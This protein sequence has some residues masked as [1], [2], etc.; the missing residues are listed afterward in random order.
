MSDDTINGLIIGAT[1]V[2]VWTMLQRRQ[3]PRAPSTL[4][5]STPT[6]TMAA[7]WRAWTPA[8]GA[9][10]ATAAPVAPG[11]DGGTSALPVRGYLGTMI[12]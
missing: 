2:V 7:A 3:R 12:Q 6:S 5:G 4:N 8:Y 11:G 1:I 9:W 10:A